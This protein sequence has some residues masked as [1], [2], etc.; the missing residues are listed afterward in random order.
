MGVRAL[1]ALISL[2][3]L[4]GTGWAWRSY[5]TALT[6][7]I[8]S[9]A[10]QD[11]PRSPGADRNILV[12]G[13]DS[14]LDEHGKPLP[15]D[16]YD[17]LHAGDDSVGGHNAN[18]LIL[19]HIPGDGSRATAISIPRDDYVA[20][21]AA[22]CSAIT[23]RGKIKQ[24]YGFAYARAKSALSAT[25]TDQ[26]DL[27]QRSRDAGRKAQIATVRAF[28]GGVPIDHFVEVTLVAFFQ[29][30]DAVQP[31]TV[32]LNENT[33][34]PYYSGADFRRGVQQI[35]AAQAMAFVR[36]RRD[37]H[38]SLDFTDLDRTRRQQAFIVSVARKLQDAGTLT[39]L[40]TVSG[41]LTIAQRNLA[42]DA[43][44]DL[45]QFASQASDLMA[46]GL[47]LY[48]LP[49]QGFGTT[50]AGEDVN[51]VDPAGIRG[52]VHNLIDPTG[53]DGSPLSSLA[54][55]APGGAVPGTTAPTSSGASTAPGGTTA[56][57]TAASGGTTTVPGETTTP[58][59]A[60]APGGSTAP[61]G[62]TAPAPPLVSATAPG[63]AAPAVT[64][65]SSMDANGIPCVK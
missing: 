5:H 1:A 59:G 23:C 9:Q 42:V 13:L 6:D 19:L 18:V 58:D 60:T 26:A 28:L 43:G 33:T 8:V 7:V 24:A 55:G 31:I 37:P 47:S 52:I 14:R 49:I 48:T 11:A 29:I 64:D 53:P 35:D 36:Q 15:Q 4:A 56:S 44:L 61:G 45:P 50:A 16:M 21:D 20:L 22:A 27:E 62:T 17:A 41:L 65:L 25:V 51:L 38:P 40:G 30:A 46:G 2:A 32:C 3:I 54:G 63:A 39:D 57:G 12:M 10:L 34:D